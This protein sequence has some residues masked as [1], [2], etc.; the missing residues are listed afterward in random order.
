M[1]IGYAGQREDGRCRVFI[2]ESPENGELKKLRPLPHVVRHS[3]DG[4][5]WGYGGSG[6]ADLALSLL[7]HAVGERLAD[8]HYQ[9]L[10]REYIATLIRESGF[11][12]RQGTLR[13]WVKRQEEEKK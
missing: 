3:P 10:K 4:F 6:P 12:L 1:W 8:K 2:V 9:T 11:S 13:D 5:E 7:T